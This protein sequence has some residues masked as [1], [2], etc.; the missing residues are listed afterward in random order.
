M[1]PLAGLA[2]EVRALLDQ[3]RT[4]VERDFAA[5]GERPRRRC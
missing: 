2:A 1:K 3:A 4:V 5:L